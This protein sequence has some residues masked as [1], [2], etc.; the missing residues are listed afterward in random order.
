MSTRDRLLATA[1]TVFAERGADG[2]S[3]REIAKRAGVNVATAYHHFGSKRDMLLAIFRE[4]GFVDVGSDQVLE[5]PADAPAQARLE[6][7]IFGAW[8]LMSSGSAVI[9]V[10]IAEALKGDPDVIDVFDA[11]RE[12]GDASVRRSLINAGL[13]DAKNVHQRGWV[14][15]QVIWATFVETLMRGEL[16]WDELYARAQE[17]SRALLDSWT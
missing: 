14:V 5:F 4:L 10:M 13:A 11:W 17:S 8:M 2:G 12:Q 1:L 3:M 15:R 6:T 16:D 9:R 7:I